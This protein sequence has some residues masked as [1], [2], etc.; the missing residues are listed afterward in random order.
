MSQGK[1]RLEVLKRNSFMWAAGKTKTDRMGTFQDF[2]IWFCSESGWKE[3]PALCVCMRNAIS[4]PP[5]NS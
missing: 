5:I 4:C 3:M 2:S 1:L